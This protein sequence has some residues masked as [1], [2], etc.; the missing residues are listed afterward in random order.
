MFLTSQTLESIIQI[1]TKT[2]KSNENYFFW[3]GADGIVEMLDK[4]GFDTK[5]NDELR[6]LDDWRNVR[7]PDETEEE[8]GVGS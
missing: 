3:L 1:M 7:L 6:A 8:E 5:V 2:N 4:E